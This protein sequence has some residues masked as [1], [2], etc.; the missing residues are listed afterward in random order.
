MSVFATDSNRLSTVVKYELEP[1]LGVCREVV[2]LNDVAQTLKIG[3]VLGKVT[4]TGAYKLQDSSAADGSDVAV[5]IFLS[6]QAGNFGDLVVVAATDTKV[7]VLRRGPAIV[8]KGALTFGA[9]TTTDVQKQAIYD[10]LKAL[11]ISAETTI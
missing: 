10:A 9:G 1:N 7:L 11:G 3:A 4:A 5:A 6:N 8:A 2:T